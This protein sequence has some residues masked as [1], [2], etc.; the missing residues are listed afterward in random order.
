MK[1]LLIIGGSGFFGKSI[2]DAYRRGL[3]DKWEI[4]T[5]CIFARHAKK[6]E[7]K[8]PELLDSSITLIN[9]DI[10]TC[11]SLPN[12]DY[13][14]HAAASSDAA[15]YLIDP[16][17]E[18]KNIV[19]GTSNFCNLALRYLSHSKILYISSGIV[20]GTVNNHQTMFK[21]DDTFFPLESIPENK[22][23][24]A[25]AKRVSEK[26]IIDLGNLGISVSIARCFTFVGKYLPRDQHFAIGNFIQNGLIKSAIQIKTNSKVY[27]SYMYVD[28][29]VEWL[30]AIMLNS[31]IRAPIYNVGSREFLEIRNLAGIVASCFGGIQVVQNKPIKDIDFYV[32]NIDKAKN[33]LNLECKY[34]TEMAI[35]E[36]VKRLQSE[37]Y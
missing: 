16:N 13:V 18:Q 26:G 17:S 34:S 37:K 1:S 10:A 20:Y 15:N 21:E 31:N 22:R 30:M 28:D 29:L 27:R 32:P 36:T 24:Y 6:L 35:S 23:H 5:I 7:I 4:S 12:A 2:L 11:Q 19:A 9:G 33:I 3:L 8:N 14:I 25:H